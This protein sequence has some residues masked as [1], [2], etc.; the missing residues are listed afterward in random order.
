MIKEIDSLIVILK[1]DFYEVNSKPVF[2]S[3]DLSWLPSCDKE[4]FNLLEQS[5]DDLAFKMSL[6]YKEENEFALELIEYMRSYMLDKS[7]VDIS[8]Q[9]LFIPLVSKKTLSLEKIHLTEGNVEEEK[10]SRVSL[11]GATGAESSSEKSEAKFK[12]KKKKKKRTEIPAKLDEILPEYIQDEEER[13]LVKSKLGR[14]KEI[15]YL[16]LKMHLANKESAGKNIQLEIK[17]KEQ[18]LELGGT[19]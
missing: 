17:L 16:L 5:K 12:K 18:E 14:E 10:G 9:A 13:A 15:Y 1:E 4:Y 6:I 3:Y 8:K 7:T 2:P 11:S 19:Y